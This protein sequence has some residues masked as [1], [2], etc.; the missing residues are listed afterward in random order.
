M[1]IEYKFE[2]PGGRTY[3]RIIENYEKLNLEG[4][5]MTTNEP[6]TVTKKYSIAN[7]PDVDITIER[8]RKQFNPTKHNFRFEIIVYSDY[9]IIDVLSLSISKNDTRLEWLPQNE[10]LMFNRGWSINKMINI[11]GHFGNLY[12]L[13]LANEL[14]AVDVFLANE[15]G[16]IDEA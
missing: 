14:P 5:K 11:I 10:R 13:E 6:N 12:D 3:T 4:F 16:Y 9:I 1:A 2:G 8:L 15:V 7:I